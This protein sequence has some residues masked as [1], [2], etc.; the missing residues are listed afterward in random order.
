MKNI[1]SIR[2]LLTLL[3]LFIVAEASLHAQT[4]SNLKSIQP[5]VLTGAQFPEFAGVPVGEI[6]LWAFDASTGSWKA[7]PFQIDKRGRSGSYFSADGTVLD[8]NDEL[9]FMTEDFGEAASDT[10]WISDAASQN[11]PRYEIVA[12]DPTDPDAKMYAYLYHTAPPTF[13][14]LVSI[15]PH[16]QDIFSDQ[17]RIGFGQNGLPNKIVVPASAGGSDRDFLDRLKIH[18]IA[19]VP[20]FSGPTQIQISENGIQKQGVKF[21]V[22]PVRIIRSIIFKIVVNAGGLG[23]I[24]LPDTFYFPI[25]FYPYSM[26]VQADSIDLSVTN[27]FKIKILS[28]RY[29]LDLN[30]NASGMKFYN[31]NNSGILID[32]Q[33]DQIN[34][35]IQ[36]GL[37]Y[38]MVTGNPGTLVS[39]LEVP[40]IGSQ[41]Q[42]YYC[43][44]TTGST[45]DGTF[46]TGDS[47]SYGDAGFRVAG[48]DI[49]GVLRFWSTVY[50]LP[51]NQPP[52]TGAKLLAD[53]Q[54]PLA[55][56]LSLQNSRVSVSESGHQTQGPASFRVN[57]AYPNPFRADVPGNQ[58]YFS[59]VLPQPLPVL[60]T[61]F[62][63]TGRMVR[64]MSIPLQ[65]AGT[66]AISWNGV[67][68]SGALLPSGIYF[69]RVQAGRFHAIRKL[70]LVR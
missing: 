48:S 56:S 30:P 15:D 57:A 32:G 50:M 38:Q 47:L 54:N 17:Y 4:S 26:A 8:A 65:S 68:G 55:F 31:P 9:V 1:F 46:D 25:Y 58:T 64:Q 44:S 2:G 14:P 6:S 66:H 51:G 60:I 12:T 40:A 27:Q 3:G 69:Y 59:Y 67:D 35:E 29:S 61:V 18:I 62:D 7:L 13:Q 22:G 42:L 28:A 43:E 10:N 63:I 23:Q 49:Q 39:L 53:I 33:P 36:P 24:S 20:G 16:T 52:D 37:N 45:C 5:V 21:K 70:L 11:Y 41:Q 34:N 19:Q